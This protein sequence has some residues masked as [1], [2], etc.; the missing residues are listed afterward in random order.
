MTCNPVVL[1]EEKV[2][3]G[4]VGKLEEELIV[5]TWIEVRLAW[6]STLSSPAT[7]S[8]GLSVPARF[9]FKSK[10]LGKKFGSCELET[11]RPPCRPLPPRSFNAIS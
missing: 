8:V 9:N 1:V 5:F 2:L 4:E 11:R 10:L 3:K 6:V 7:K